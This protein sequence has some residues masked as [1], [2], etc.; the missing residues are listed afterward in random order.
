MIVLGVLAASLLLFRAAGALGVAA[1]ASWV[2]S[3]RWALAVVFTFT[4]VAH[5]TKV[6]HT[7]ARMV[8]RGLGHAM[9]IV[10]FTGVCEIA[11]AIG[12]F[13]PRTRAIAGVCLIIFLVAIFPANV[14]A[15]R[16]RMILGGHPA[17]PLIPRTAMQLLLVG[18]V[19]WTTLS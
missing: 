5:F 18:L 8:P 4:G 12:I 17:T 14:K 7:M 11:G 19:W 15:A 16:E 13:L 10:Y 6:R 2:A 1:L 9:A 3:T